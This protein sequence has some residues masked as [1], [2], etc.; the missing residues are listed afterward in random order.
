MINKKKRICIIVDF[1]VPADHKLK[2]KECEKKYKYLLLA[3]EM[4]KT[5]EHAGDNCTNRDWFFWY[6][7]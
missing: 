2:L 4:K 3:K 6:S 7:N 5:M 1:A